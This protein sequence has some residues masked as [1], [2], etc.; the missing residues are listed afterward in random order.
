MTQTKQINLA[1]TKEHKCSCGSNVFEQ[2]FFL[3]IIPALL[4]GTLKR[5]MLPIQVFRC[6][7]CGLQAEI[8]QK[9]T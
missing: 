5:E 7:N 1:D 4:S 6:V 8:N 3:R 2:V 9:V